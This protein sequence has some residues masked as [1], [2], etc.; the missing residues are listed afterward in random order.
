MESENN[1]NTA[2]VSGDLASRLA[3]GGALGGYVSTFVA[4]PK[5]WKFC[6]QCSQRLE[7]TWN[8][9]GE[10]GERLHGEYPRW[11]YTIPNETAWVSPQGIWTVTSTSG[12]DQ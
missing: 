4:H 3:T 10:C 6:P 9:C 8:F 5:P 2:S 11:S 1:L 7:V 12:Q